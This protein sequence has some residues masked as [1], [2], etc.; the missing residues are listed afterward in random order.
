MDCRC[1]L[2]RLARHSCR[3]C[4]FNQSLAGVMRSLAIPEEA[5]TRHVQGPV[6]FDELLELLEEH[7]VT[8]ETQ[9]G[10]GQS[11]RP[12]QLQPHAHLPSSPA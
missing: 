1:A 5:P 6:S 12:A 2:C 7:A 10:G 3:T 9:V 11:F 4:S 8:H